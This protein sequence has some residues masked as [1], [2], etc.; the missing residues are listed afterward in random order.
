MLNEVPSNIACFAMAHWK[1]SDAVKL[2][3]GLFVGKY[4]KQR[5]MQHIPQHCRILGLL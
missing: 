3:S 1:R 2:H 5:D 4:R